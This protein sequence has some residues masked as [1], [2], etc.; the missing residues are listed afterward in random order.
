M[1]E[2]VWTNQ[3]ERVLP[4]PCF[5]SLFSR[6]ELPTSRPGSLDSALPIAATTGRHYHQRLAC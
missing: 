4:I 6:R 3:L 5:E 2:S 1:K